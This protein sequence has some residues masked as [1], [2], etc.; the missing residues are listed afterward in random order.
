M[1]RKKS[2]RPTAPKDL[3]DD[4]KDLWNS[5]CDDLDQLG[6]LQK[7]DRKLI[8]VYVRD[9]LLA[10]RVELQ[11]ATEDLSLTCGN[12]RKFV[13]PLATLYT[14]ITTKLRRTLHELG[15]TPVR[16]KPVPQD[17]PYL[18]DAGNI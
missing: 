12:G 15:L 7:V 17:N 1:A 14:N 2:T 13:N 9:A 5:V 3:T 10:R 6:T 16:R 18:D 8:E 11:L 4:G